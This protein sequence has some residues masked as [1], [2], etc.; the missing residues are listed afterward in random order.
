MLNFSMLQ[1]I[2]FQKDPDL[3]SNQNLFYL[4]GK[5]LFSGENAFAF[6]ASFQRYD[7]VTF[8]NSFSL[9]KW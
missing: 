4:S 5:P 2:I 9:K 6:L 3:D 1:N 7:F 8:L